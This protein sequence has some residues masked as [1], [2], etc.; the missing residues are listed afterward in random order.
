MAEV[1]RSRDGLSDLR[2]DFAGAHEMTDGC[3]TQANHM[4]HPP[5]CTM[6][7]IS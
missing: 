5:M 1:Y 7:G 2:R 6:P 3:S 4:N